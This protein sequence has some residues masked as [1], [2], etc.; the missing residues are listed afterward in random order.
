MIDSY[1]NLMIL[2]SLLFFTSSFFRFWLSSTYDRVV[3]TLAENQTPLHTGPY[4]SRDLHQKLI[5]RSRWSLNVHLLHLHQPSCPTSPSPKHHLNGTAS[6]PSL[7]RHG[8]NH[9]YDSFTFS[10][11][12]TKLNRSFSS[13]YSHPCLS[14]GGGTFRSFRKRMMPIRSPYSTTQILLGLLPNF[15]GQTLLMMRIGKNIPRAQ[16]IFP[17][18]GN[19]VDCSCSL[20][21]ARASPT[22]FIAGSCR[23]FLSWLRCFTGL[24]P[25]I[26]IA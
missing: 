25:I 20:L 4:W 23:N 24:L 9:L 16:S 1:T 21:T 13:S 6:Q 18:V 7:C 2:S 17:S 19:T 26:S 22:T 3:L 12:M 10:D 5:H 14:R 11:V 15:C 8:E